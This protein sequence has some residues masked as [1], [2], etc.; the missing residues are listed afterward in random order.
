MKIETTAPP[1]LVP[2]QGSSLSGLG[3]IGLAVS[4][5]SITLLLILTIIIGM[6]KDMQAIKMQ[7]PLLLILFLIGTMVHI[8]LICIVYM[9]AELCSASHCTTDF[10]DTAKTAG[11]LV[12]CFAEPLLF[13]AYMF[14]FVR[15]K[16]IFDA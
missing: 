5:L 9:N 1:L 14:R 2:P 16:N 4:A 7:S 13:I 8:G 3:I 15:I 11:Y 10:S 12:V 6:R